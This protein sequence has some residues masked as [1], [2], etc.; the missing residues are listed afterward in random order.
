MESIQ[1]YLAHLKVHISG[2]KKEKII[3]A[4]LF[5]KTLVEAA[6]LNE[7]QRNFTM[8]FYCKQQTL[9]FL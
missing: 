1:L 7:W 9:L 5:K 6:I 2:T 8:I 4:T 3:E